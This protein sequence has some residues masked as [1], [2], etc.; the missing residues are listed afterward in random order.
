MK[1]FTLN[2]N[3]YITPSTN[4]FQNWSVIAVLRLLILSLIVLNCQS[5]VAQATNTIPSIK[6]ANSFLDELKA[7]STLEYKNLDGFLHNLNPAIYTYD[8]TLKVYNE[9]GENCTILFSDMSSLDFIKNNTIPSQNVE[10]V[11]IEITKNTELSEKKIDLSIFDNFPK[12]KYI[13]LYSR[14][15]SNEITFNKMFSNYQ[16]KYTIIYIINYGE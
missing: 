5:S 7:N 11:Q 10:M 9:N 4:N 12:L 3:S 8:N 13:C 6:E 2:Q 16:S 1:N 15:P 14:I